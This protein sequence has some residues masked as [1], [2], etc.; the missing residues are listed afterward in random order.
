MRP[1]RAGVAVP[2]SNR[3]EAT[4]TRAGSWRCESV[5]GLF[6]KVRCCR[7]K[8]HDGMHSG[9]ADVGRIVW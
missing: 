2:G 7:R 4:M 3:R 5:W 9:R 1:L 6:D 8:G